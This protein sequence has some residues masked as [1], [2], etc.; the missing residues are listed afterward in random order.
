MQ[1]SN[2]D[3][4]ELR[5]AGSRMHDLGHDMNQLSYREVYSYQGDFPR[6][7]NHH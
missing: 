2:R 1:V 3:R 5:Q 4:L 6:I 7:Y